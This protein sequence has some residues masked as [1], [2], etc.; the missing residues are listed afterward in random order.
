[1]GCTE[2]LVALGTPIFLWVNYAKSENILTF[3]LVEVVCTLL[4]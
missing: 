2:M 1:M 3:A 4:Q